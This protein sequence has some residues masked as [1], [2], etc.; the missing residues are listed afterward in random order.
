V[1]ITN[2]KSNHTPPHAARHPSAGGEYK[3]HTTAA[4][5]DGKANEAVI[6]LLADHLKIPKSKIKLLRGA[7]GRDKVFLV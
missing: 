2:F 6:R 3:I 7:A 5:A 4:P 1:S